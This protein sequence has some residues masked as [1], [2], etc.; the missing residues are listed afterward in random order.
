[1][2]A[3]AELSVGSPQ[4]S[5]S[6]ARMDSCS[7]QDPRHEMKAGDLPVSLTW[8]T[9]AN[10]G[11]ADTTAPTHQQPR[12]RCRCRASALLLWAGGELKERRRPRG[13]FGDGA[14]VSDRPGSLLAAHSREVRVALGMLAPEAEQDW[15][16]EPR[17]VGGLRLYRSR[18]GGGRFAPGPATRRSSPGPSSGACRF[19]VASYHRP[20]AGCRARATTSTS[21]PSPGCTLV[22]RSGQVTRAARAPLS[23]QQ[24][25]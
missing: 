4:R 6:A 2:Q 16:P 12:R 13:R 20:L 10:S 22:G 23:L 7:R 19:R 18:R 15:P 8:L 3:R 5:G 24:A 17:R 14:V 1:M 25:Y 21:S 11:F 9:F